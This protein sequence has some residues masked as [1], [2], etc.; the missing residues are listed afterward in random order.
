MKYNII[1]FP[2]NDYLLQMYNIPSEIY[3]SIFQFIPTELLPGVILCDSTFPKIA[4]VHIPFKNNI[5][6]AKAFDRKALSVLYKNIHFT[7]ELILYGAAYNQYFDIVDDLLERNLTDPNYDEG[8]L[9]KMLLAEI[10][11]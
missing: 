5:N 10:L 6:N 9:I 4:L 1:I 3:G 11:M 2:K 7:K 8:T